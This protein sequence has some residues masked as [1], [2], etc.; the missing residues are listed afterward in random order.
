MNLIY[1]YAHVIWSMM[2]WLHAVFKYDPPNDTVFP[3]SE[4]LLPNLWSYLRCDMSRA[5]MIGNTRHG[6]R[7]GFQFVPK[8]VA[9][10]LLCLR[11]TRRPPLE[12]RQDEVHGPAAAPPL[13]L[14][15]SI[16]CNNMKLR[17][18]ACN[19]IFEHTLRIKLSFKHNDWDPSWSEHS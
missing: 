11:R 8:R 1:F 2:D 14:L 6:R 18:H 13:A 16:Q 3:H 12:R 19:N 10:L 17:K 4:Y 15:A 5:K 7:E 9:A